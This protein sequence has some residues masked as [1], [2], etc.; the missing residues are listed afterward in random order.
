MF[1][2]FN[3]PG[4]FIEEMPTGLAQLSSAATGITAFVGQAPE[5]PVNQPQRCHSLADVTR[6]FGPPQADAELGPA[7]AQFFLNGG[8]QAWVL[9]I[10]D[11]LPPGEAHL[12][13]LQVLLAPER[14]DSFNLLCLPGVS[15]PAVLQAAVAC[16]EARRALLLVD[17]PESMQSPQQMLD[18]IH[19]GAWPQSSHAALYFPWLHIDDPLHP[20]TL[21]RVPPSGSIAGLMARTDAQRGVWRAPAGLDA[22]LR[23]A[24]QPA[25]PLD[26]ADTSL[27]NPWGVNGLREFPGQGVLCW[28]ARTLRGADA[29]GDDF[30]YV[31]VRRLALFLEDSLQ[32]GTGWVVFEPNGEALWA[33]LRLQVEAFLNGLFRQ[34]A[35]QGQSAREAYLVRCGEDTITAQDRALGLV[36]LQLG[37]APLRPAE[38]VMLN[39][40]LQ[41]AVEA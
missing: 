6:H 34:G 40:V 14:V 36:R 19:S 16:C 20:G 17:P 27:L 38:F 3:A 21:R 28:G 29:L 12:Q 26:D 2:H 22:Q 32:Q 39:L 33:R 15:E 25:W 30:K 10:D 24:L 5:G 18:G 13:A 4:V 23:G 37:F 35:F 8:S 1:E 31:P 11:S 41:A 9:R 7:L